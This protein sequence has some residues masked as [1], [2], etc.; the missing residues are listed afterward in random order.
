[1]LKRSSCIAIFKK[2]CIEI[3]CMHKSVSHRYVKNNAE[4]R[5]IEQH[6]LCTSF[7]CSL[8]YLQI[9]YCGTS[10][11]NTFVSGVLSSLLLVSYSCISCIQLPAKQPVYLWG[12]IT[13][14]PAQLN[15]SSPEVFLFIFFPSNLFMSELDFSVSLSTIA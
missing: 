8:F 10:A 12:P 3:Y 5:S 15:F 9:L 6:S 11:L 2:I 14:Y 1:M 13:L 4:V 7:V